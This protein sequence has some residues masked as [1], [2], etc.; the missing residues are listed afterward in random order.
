MKHAVQQDRRYHGC[1]CGYSPTMPTR[2]VLE[3][4]CTCRRVLRTSSGHTNVAVKAPARKYRGSYRYMSVVPSYLPSSGGHIAMYAVIGGQGCAQL[5][6]G[7]L[8]TV[9]QLDAV[10]VL[11]QGCIG[12]KHVF[13]CLTTKYTR[14]LPACVPAV[15]SRA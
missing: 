10:C 7:L 8:S 13:C 6:C 9:L 15:C 14:S 3:M 4:H 1:C 12:I 5:L 2:C 11:T